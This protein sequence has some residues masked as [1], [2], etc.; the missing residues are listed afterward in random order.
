MKR[1]ISIV[2]ALALVLSI[3]QYAFATNP[4]LSNFKK[5]NQYEAGTF[6]DIDGNAWYAD[7]VRIA[8]EMGLVNGNSET[9]FN[10]TGNMTI[11]EAITLA[12]RLNSYYY[13]GSAEFT[14]GTPW[15]QVYVDYAVNAGI[16]AKG[17]FKNYN[18][19]AT[20][21]QF[22]SIFGKAFPE[23]ALQAINLIN[24]GDVPDVSGIETYSGSV[25]LLYNAGV[26]TGSDK[27]GTFNPNSNI[28]RSEVAT[29]T[30]RMADSGLRKTFMLEIPAT[31]V[32]LSSTALSLKTGETAALTATILPSNV[33]DKTTSWK[34][35]N[36]SVATVSS[37]GVVTGI[38]DGVAIITV[39]TANGKT[40]TCTISVETDDDSSDN[41]NNTD[42][43]NNT[44]PA[45]PTNFTAVAYSADKA[46]LSW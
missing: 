13:N 10:P 36:L 44:S 40:A 12:S 26:L 41:N 35:S 1:F 32:S 38:K 37:A 4:S 25:Y 34:S 8:Y 15:Y 24:S 19:L 9:S 29:I 23:T 46:T 21:A 18:S 6:K 33:T 22:A 3:G 27:Y 28:T 42:T 17:Q 16:V 20:R 11:A 39:L 2:F 31:D 30:T 7:Y 5:N 43:N 45:A 14:Q